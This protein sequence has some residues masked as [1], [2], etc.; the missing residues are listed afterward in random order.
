M[1]SVPL[2]KTLRGLRVGVGPIAQLA[3]GL[4][5]NLRPAF[6]RHR[7]RRC[8][9]RSR[10]GRWRRRWRRRRVR[11][12]TSEESAGDSKT[13]HLQRAEFTL[14]VASPGFGSPLCISC[15]EH[16]VGVFQACCWKVKLCKEQIGRPIVHLWSVSGL[17]RRC[18]A[19]IILHRQWKTPPPKSPRRICP[20][21]KPR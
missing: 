4:G 6:E 13:G 9:W 8:R 14:H 16:G 7:T 19:F 18:L 1:V 10:D 12:H 11:M 17:F 2:E 15:V 3:R 20:P 21:R 5:V